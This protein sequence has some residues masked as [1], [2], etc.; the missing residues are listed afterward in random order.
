M[1]DSGVTSAVRDWMDRNI[2]PGVLIW[3]TAQWFGSKPQAVKA[4]ETTPGVAKGQA[5]TVM[6]TGPSGI[7]LTATPTIL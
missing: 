1:V 3:F 5:V 2:A 6:V 4:E 7:E